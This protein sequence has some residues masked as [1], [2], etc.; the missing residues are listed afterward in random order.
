MGSLT[1][2][3]LAALDC[4]LWSTIVTWLLCAFAGHQLFAPWIV[5]TLGLSRLGLVV[6]TVWRYDLDWHKHRDRILG[7]ETESRLSYPTSES[8]ESKGGRAI[9]EQ[10]RARVGKSLTGGK[11]FPAAATITTER[12]EGGTNGR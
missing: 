3:L 7:S 12:A 2:V 6:W 1:N 9:G 8:T 5:I 4:A 11:S 10:Q